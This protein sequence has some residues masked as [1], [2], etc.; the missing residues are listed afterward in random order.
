MM[1]SAETEEIRQ[2]FIDA[3]YDQDAESIGRL[4]DSWLKA[5]RDTAWFEAYKEGFQEGKDNWIFPGVVKSWPI[6]GDE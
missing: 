3:N 4:F 6:V 2:A 5:E 1:Y